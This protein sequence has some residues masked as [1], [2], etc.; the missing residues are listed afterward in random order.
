MRQAALRGVMTEQEAVVALNEY[1]DALRIVTS[2]RSQE[3]NASDS[4]Y[5]PSF[6]RINTVERI[7]A[8]EGS[9][10]VEWK[11]GTDD[12][13]FERVHCIG[14]RATSPLYTAPDGRRT[15]DFCQSF[16]ERYVKD[17]ETG[18]VEQFGAATSLL[19]RLLEVAALEV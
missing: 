16:P 4:P 5:N 2:D 11:P 1:K 13:W 9:R 7:E 18:K 8:I 3:P 10:I 19:A 12:A 6:N 14:Y 17:E 15:A